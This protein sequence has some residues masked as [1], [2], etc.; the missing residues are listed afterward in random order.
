VIMCDGVEMCVR[1]TSIWY[2]YDWP[3]KT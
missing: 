3:A 1:Q 2:T